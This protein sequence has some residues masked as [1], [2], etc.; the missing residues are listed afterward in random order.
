MVIVM[1]SVIFMVMVAFGATSLIEFV[2]SPIEAGNREVVTIHCWMDY[3]HLARYWHCCHPL[4]LF[5]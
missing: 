3:W 5:I 2:G 4:M 1:V